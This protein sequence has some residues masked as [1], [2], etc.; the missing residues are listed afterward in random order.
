MI[1]RVD[2][3]WCP[4]LLPCPVPVTE[5]G[6]T[7][8]ADGQPL[9]MEDRTRECG[10]DAGWVIG[11]QLSCDEHTRLAC[12]FMGVDYDELEREAREGGRA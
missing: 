9:P 2:F 12:G 6:R 10:Q 1:T 7:L 5:D 8:D 3:T 11:A 4:L